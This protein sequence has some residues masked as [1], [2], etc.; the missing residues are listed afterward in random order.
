MEQMKQTIED[1]TLEEQKS[2]INWELMEQRC[3]DAESLKPVLPVFI[4]SNRQNVSDLQQAWDNDDKKSIQSIAH[5]IKGTAANVGAEALSQVGL[6]L[7]QGCRDGDLD[8]GEELIQQIK[9]L[10]EEL[11]A[12]ISSLD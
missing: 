3:L 2:P 11:D 8:D 10:H 5:T 6:L 12:Y 7:E 4:E 9:Q 1:K